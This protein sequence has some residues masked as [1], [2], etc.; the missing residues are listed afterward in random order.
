MLAILFQ[1]KHVR[2]DLPKMKPVPSWLLNN[3]LH[4]CSLWSSLRKY[5]CFVVY[6]MFE[7]RNHHV[8]HSSHIAAFRACI[9]EFMQTT[10]SII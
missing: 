10:L 4:V 9:Y 5:V 8:A 7:I 3:F 6:R 1:T 2:S